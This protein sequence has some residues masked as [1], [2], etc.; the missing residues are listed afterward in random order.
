MPLRG[1]VSRDPEG[2]VVAVAAV[3][4]QAPEQLPRRGVLG[5]EEVPIVAQPDG[6]RD[7]HDIVGRLQPQGFVLAGG[8]GGD[9]PQLDPVGEGR[10]PQPL[11]LRRAVRLDAL[12]PHD[13]E[14]PPGG[15]RRVAGLPLV[16]ELPH[17][18]PVLHVQQGDEALAHHGHA[19]QPQGPDGQRLGDLVLLP[20]RL[21]R[22]GL[23]G[24]PVRPEQPDRPLGRQGQDRPVV[25]RGH[26]PERLAFVE[27]PQQPSFRRVLREPAVPGH[28]RV[29]E[30][31]VHG[32][33]PRRGVQRSP[34]EHRAAG[35][36]L[37]DLAG[38][39]H[40]GLALG[41]HGDVVGDVLARVERVLPLGRRQ[42]EEH[43]GALR[44]HRRGG[45]QRDQPYHKQKPR[46]TP[47]ILPHRGPPWFS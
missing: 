39:H 26:V 44:E 16:G 47:F 3:V 20:P 23:E 18:L 21:R 37:D 14:Q 25:E 8:Q 13:D 15:E 43:H 1:E 36:V 32:H 4:R 22:Q 12:R 10:P 35:G 38:P 30:Q 27:A 42:V 41:V 5:R 7:Q 34:P 9:G 17:D 28:D 33:R 31:R 45:P 40:H 19:P 24:P 29:A 2:H 6:S 46:S 11:P